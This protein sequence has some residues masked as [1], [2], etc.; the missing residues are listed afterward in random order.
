MREI[1]LDTETTGLSPQDGHRIVEIGCVELVNH[2]VSGPDE[3]KR[4]FYINPERP[5]PAEAFAVHGL[6]GEFLADKPVFADIAEDFLNFIGDSPLII[7][8]AEFDMRFLNAE[9]KRLGLPELPKSRAVDTLA[10]ARRR[11]PG[12][13]AS[14]DALCRRY[15]IDTSARTLHGALLDSIL[16][17]EVYLELIGGRQ[18]GLTLAET[19]RQSDDQLAVSRRT[20]RPARPH[21]P[22][23][24]ELDAH[25]ALLDTLTKPI[26]RS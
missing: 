7:H 12:A 25:N 8:N 15:D 23:A 3:G 16:L 14:L 20:P 11:F 24:A 18:P 21:A 13:Q 5:M 1:V 9:L 2:V 26:W 19:A 17:A 4:Q 6:S 22:S 10:I